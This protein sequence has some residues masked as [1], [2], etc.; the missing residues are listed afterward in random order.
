MKKK[1]LQIVIGLFII[2]NG[3]FAQAWNGSNPTGDAWRDGKVGIGTSNIPNKLSVFVNQQNDGIWLGGQSSKSIALLQNTTIGAYNSLTQPGDN[4]L[5]WGTTTGDD[6]NAGG[7]VIAT[8]STD[9][10]GMR[11]TSAGDVGI[12]TPFPSSKFHVKG[13]NLGLNAGDRINLFSTENQCGHFNF[14]FVNIYSYRNDAGDSWYTT[15]TRIENNI[16]GSQK[17]FI[18]FNPKGLVGGL[19]LGTNNAQHLII[20]EGGNVSVGTTNAAAKLNVNFFNPDGVIP[21]NGLLLQTNGFYTEDN[22]KN[23]YYLKTLDQGNGA[24]DFIVKGNG[25]VGIGTDNIGSFKLAVNGSIGA[26]EIRVTWQDPFPDYVFDS[27]YKLR[28]L[29]SLENYINQN[30]HLPGVP[31]AVEV[32]KKGGIDLGQMNTKLLEKIEELTLYIIEI[33]KKVEK[34]ELE[35]KELKKNN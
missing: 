1:A 29:N 27:K 4:L 26:H 13:L 30:K 11:I 33:N 17:G 22:A 18:E 7:L 9:Y 20:N 15:S 28:S 25:T 3:A 32:E 10:K 24:V 19:A 6:P 16:D 14:A 23:S 34:L 31:S 2:S 12:G 8:R 35:N 21:Q 5:L